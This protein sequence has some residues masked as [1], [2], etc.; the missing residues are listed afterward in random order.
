M[1]G[2]DV[3][4]SHYCVT[5]TKPAGFGQQLLSGPQLYCPAGLWFGRGPAGHF[6]GL[7]C[8]RGCWLSGTASGQVFCVPH[9][10]SAPGRPAQACCHGRSRVLREQIQA[11]PRLEGCCHFCCILA[12]TSYREELKRDIAKDVGTGEREGQTTGAILQSVYLREGRIGCGTQKGG[13][14]SLPEKGTLRDL[15]HSRGQ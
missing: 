1:L 6:S 4:V 7:G 13:E 14:G 2:V 11:R 8:V 9:G 5:I 3:S 12:T 15:K 10:H